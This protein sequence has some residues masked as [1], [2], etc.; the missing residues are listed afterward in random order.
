MLA[1]GF[2]LGPE[3][4]WLG[5]FTLDGTLVWQCGPGPGFPNRVIDVGL[6]VDGSWLVLLDESQEAGPIA[7]TLDAYDRDGRGLSRKQIADDKVAALADLP[8]GKTVTLD[9]HHDGFVA[10]R[11]DHVERIG[12]DGAVRWRSPPGIYSDAVV[13]PDGQ[14]VALAW[15]KPPFNEP[16]S[17]RLV[18]FVDP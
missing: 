1:G 2:G 15:P 13:A 9:K 8:E 18:R 7:R 12:R 5:K 16:T 6:R 4:W 14:V 10:D 17:I 11:T 3:A